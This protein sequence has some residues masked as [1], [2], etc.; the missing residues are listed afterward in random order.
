MNWDGSYLIELNKRFNLSNSIRIG[1]TLPVVGEHTIPNMYIKADDYKLYAHML[2]NFTM[3][4]KENNLNVD[5]DCVLHQCMFSEEQI[6]EMGSSFKSS[7]F[8]E[9]IIDIGVDLDVYRCFTFSAIYNNTKLYDYDSVSELMGYYEHIDKD[10]I[11]DGG[12]MNNCDYCSAKD[13]T[14]QG[15]CLANQWLHKQIRGQKNEKIV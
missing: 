6:D 13:K 11:I 9:P 4:C 8:C 1:M 15:G 10:I 14:C 5:Y 2:H 3:K 7:S 12:C